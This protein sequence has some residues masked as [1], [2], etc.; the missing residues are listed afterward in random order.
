MVPDT[1]EVMVEAAVPV[2]VPASVQEA[3]A[4]DAAPKISMVQY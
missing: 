4:P 2:H 3:D 1:E